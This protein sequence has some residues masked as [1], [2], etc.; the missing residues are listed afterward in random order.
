MSYKVE[1]T[2]NVKKETKKLVKRYPSLKSEL[3]NLFTELEE[4][5]T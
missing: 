3:A 5:P 4:N 1:L 2:T